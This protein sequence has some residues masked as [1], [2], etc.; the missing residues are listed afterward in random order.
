MLKPSAL[1]ALMQRIIHHDGE[2]LD[3]LKRDV[4]AYP[5]EH[6]QKPLIDCAARHG[7]AELFLREDADGEE[8]DA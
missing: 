5:D 7:L 8:A 4:L 3:A 6:Q 1:S 2:D